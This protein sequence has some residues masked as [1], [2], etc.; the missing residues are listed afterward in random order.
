[1]A[2]KPQEIQDKTVDGRLAKFF[3]KICLMDQKFI[4]DDKANI[5]TLVK[6]KVATF[7]EKL[8]LRR[9]HFFQV[10]A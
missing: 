6:Q 10:G 8:V 4:K 9:F 3:E 5:E 1:M 2:G 7:G